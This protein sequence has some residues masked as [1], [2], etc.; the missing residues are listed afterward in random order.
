MFTL[1]IQC[2][3]CF[4]YNNSL[5][6]YALALCQILKLTKKNKYNGRGIIKEIG[7]KNTAN[8]F[9]ISSSAKFGGEIGW[10]KSS[11]LSND[12]YEKISNS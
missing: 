3:V 4:E 8:I 10:I 2:Y 6:F 12:I 1:N 11:Q 9:S 5:S 7:F